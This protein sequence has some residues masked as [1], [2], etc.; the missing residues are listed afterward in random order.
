MDRPEEKSVCEIERLP[1]GWT[2]QANKEK[3]RQTKPGFI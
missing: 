1:D 3:P 2:V